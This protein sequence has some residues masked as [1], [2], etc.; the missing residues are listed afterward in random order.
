VRVQAVHPWTDSLLMAWQGGA[1]IH[2]RTGSGLMTCQACDTLVNELYRAEDGP[3]ASARFP[4]GVCLLCF[5]RLIA[6]L[7]T[8]DE[9]QVSVVTEGLVQSR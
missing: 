2:R 8:D 3:A 1:A 5:V 4:C 7:P 6:R 9:E